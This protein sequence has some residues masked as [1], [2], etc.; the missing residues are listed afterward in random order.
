VAEAGAGPE[1]LTAEI[2]PDLVT[3]SRKEFPALADRR[4]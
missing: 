3:R 1:V 2:D 4:L